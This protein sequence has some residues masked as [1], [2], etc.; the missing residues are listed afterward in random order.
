MSCFILVQFF[1]VKPTHKF[2]TSHPLVTFI[3]NFQGLFTKLDN[4][5]TPIFLAAFL[6]IT[7]T[8]TSLNLLILMTSS[9]EMNL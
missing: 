1:G 7:L 4:Y 8:P 6:K 2:S 3:T 9:W 5:D